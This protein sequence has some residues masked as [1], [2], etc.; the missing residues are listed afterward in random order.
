[1]SFQ[2]TLVVSLYIKTSSDT[3][4]KKDL[5]EEKCQ[6]DYSQLTLFQSL[7]TGISNS[8]VDHML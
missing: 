2:T 4:N 1:M 8:I 6:T 5:E 3:Q 7:W